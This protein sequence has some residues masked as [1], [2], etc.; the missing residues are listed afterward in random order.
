[1]CI[2]DSLKAEG[3]PE[4]SIVSKYT[5]FQELGNYLDSQKKVAA[6]QQQIYK[7]GVETVENEEFYDA[8]GYF[9]VLPQ[10]YEDTGFYTCLLYTSRCV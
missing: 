3:Y 5:L 1:M 6:L 7:K 2:R 8:E 10:D 4:R 9:E